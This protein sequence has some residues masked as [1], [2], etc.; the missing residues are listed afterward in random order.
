MV[1]DGR[2]SRYGG[3]VHAG[4]MRVATASAVEGVDI[5]VVRV[6]A[7]HGV[8]TGPVVVR[9]A[10]R[11]QMNVNVN[12]NVT[13]SCGVPVEGTRETHQTERSER[14]KSRIERRPQVHGPRQDFLGADAE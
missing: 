5:T 12:V 13:L 4:A 10:E 14:A 3:E 9:L 7:S 11:A 1:H 2:A 8:S 6:C